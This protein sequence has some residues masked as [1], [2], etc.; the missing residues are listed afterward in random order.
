MRELT[1]SPVVT[2][3]SSLVFAMWHL[4]E[5]W[6]RP[7][8]A[9][10]AWLPL[11]AV[12]GLFRGIKEKA[13][14]CVAAAVAATFLSTQLGPV[15]QFSGRIVHWLPGRTASVMTVFA[16]L[17]LAMYARYV[18]CSATTL[19]KP[20]SSEDVPATKSAQAIRASA[21]SQLLLICGSVVALALA[22]GSY[23][24]A[25]MVPSLA[26]G[27]WLVFRLRGYASAW[28]PHIVFWALLFGYLFLRSRLV[29][30]EVSGYQD[31]QF[32]TGPGVWIVLGEYLL[33]MVYWL[34]SQAVSFGGAWIL[35]LTTELWSPLLAALGNAATYLGAW[36]DG[37][38][39]WWFFGFLLFAFVAFLP[40][41][42]LQPFGH[43]HYLPSVFRAAFVVAL[44]AVV[45]R[46][47]AS[48]VSPLEL[49]APQRSGP[50]PG[51]LLR[52]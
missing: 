42:W 17:S 18:R 35:L 2:G 43:Y 30:S 40:M 48:A 1:D 19:R 5:S 46:L 47:V 11:V 27:V 32:R 25:V 10:V 44:G 28:W 4:G 45:L 6:V 34:Y 9:I 36:R 31:Q 29:P 50:A 39:R 26:L 37:Q 14:V 41:A 12:L 16:L 21:T 33:P 23:E 13:L 7:V 38:W 52:P 20:A 8:T 3:V 49:R 24:Q 15:D 51:S 22:L